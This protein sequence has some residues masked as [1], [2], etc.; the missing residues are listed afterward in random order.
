M[1]MGIEIKN[2]RA[3][4]KYQLG[5]EFTAGIQLTGTE[6]K[7]IRNGKAGIGDAYCRFTGDELY[8]VN[9]YIQEYEQGTHYNHEPRRVR[10][11]LLNRSELNKIHRKVKNDGVTVVPVLL[12][13]SERG[14]AKLKIAIAKGKKLHDKRD[15]LKKKD[16]RREIDRNNKVR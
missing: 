11:L 5:D 15:D 14:F 10:K 6:I 8:V 7:S 1:T 12:F 9:M 3:S 16:H 4:Y 13:I 2:K